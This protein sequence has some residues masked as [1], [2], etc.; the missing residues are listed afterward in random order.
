MTVRVASRVRAWIGFNPA[1]FYIKFLGAQLQVN[2]LHEFWHAVFAQILGGT[3]GGVHIGFLVFYTDIDFTNINPG[4]APIVVFAG[5]LCSALMCIMWWW[6]NKDDESRIVWHAVGWTQGLYG[7]VEGVLFM[8]NR[9]DLVGPVGLV[10]MILGAIFA[11]A[12]S[13]IMWEGRAQ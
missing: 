3:V 6:A 7:I 9:Y 12:R 5:G 10:A 2:W 8:M 4:L 11:F 1:E 13:G